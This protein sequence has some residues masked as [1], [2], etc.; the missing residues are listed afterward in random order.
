[1]ARQRHV[2]G[3]TVLRDRCELTVHGQRHVCTAQYARHGC[4]VQPSRGLHEASA[5]L[6][7]DEDE[8]EEEE[9]EEEQQQQQ[10]EEDFTFSSMSWEI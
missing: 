4:R 7:E 9:E 3:C 10:E 6:H 2:S 8:E 1:M 5:H